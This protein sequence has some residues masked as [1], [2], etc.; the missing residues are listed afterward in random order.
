ML[1]FRVDIADKAKKVLVN[2]FVESVKSL[3]SFA[4]ASLE[5][6]EQEFRNDFC[7]IPFT[8]KFLN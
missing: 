6:K 3:E 4:D 2:G 7:R 1:F 8:Q 5:E